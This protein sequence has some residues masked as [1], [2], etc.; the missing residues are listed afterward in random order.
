MKWGK[1]QRLE[2]QI[3]KSSSS[4]ENEVIALEVDIVAVHTTNELH[5]TQRE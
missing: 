5:G 4:I 3:L 1:K 2:N